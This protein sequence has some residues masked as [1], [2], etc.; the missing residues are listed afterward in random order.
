M[1]SKRKRK[2][3]IK[4][5]DDEE[6]SKKLSKTTSKGIDKKLGKQHIHANHVVNVK[7][8][9]LAVKMCVNKFYEGKI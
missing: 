8:I 7:F 1:E 2:V 5:D 4:S 3:S 6:I 9:V